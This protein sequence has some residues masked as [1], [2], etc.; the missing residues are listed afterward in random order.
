M[1]EKA[2]TPTLTPSL[3]I[4][5][6]WSELATKSI[7]QASFSWFLPRYSSLFS[8]VRDASRTN[9]TSTAA[10]IDRAPVAEEAA[11]AAAVLGTADASVADVC[12]RR[13]R[14]RRRREHADNSP[15]KKKKKRKNTRQRT[16]GETCER[17]AH[18]SMSRPPRLPTRARWRESMS[19]QLR[20]SWCHSNAQGRVRD[21]R[22]NG[23]TPRQ[24][25]G[26][27]ALRPGTNVRGPAAAQAVAS[28][29]LRGNVRKAR[30]SQEALRS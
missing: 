28:G 4:S 2:M 30:Q 26:T 19:H 14:R 23:P 16:G 15:K 8:V 25:M 5:I 12:R 21:M 11:E 22:A 6:S 13:R 17:H 29:G 24:R 18:V 7:D 9:S 10:H 1:F 27:R 20:R 3:P